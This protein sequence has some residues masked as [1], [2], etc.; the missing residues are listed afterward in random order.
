MV[1]PSMQFPALRGEGMHTALICDLKPVCDC[2][3]VEP[4]GSYLPI[5][6]Y[7]SRYLP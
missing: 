3:R 6:T 2:D 4:V 1:L 7:L 5:S